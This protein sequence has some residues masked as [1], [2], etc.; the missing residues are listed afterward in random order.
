MKV[1]TRE[2]ISKVILKESNTICLLQITGSTI[3]NDNP[4]YMRI[5]NEN[6]KTGEVKLQCEVQDSAAQTFHLPLLVSLY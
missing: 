6:E 4:E 2:I 3:P 5:K 1:H